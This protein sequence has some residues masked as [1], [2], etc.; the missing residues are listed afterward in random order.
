MSTKIT[1]RP[2][3]KPLKLGDIIEYQCSWYTTYEIIIAIRFPHVRTLT[4]LATEGIP[5]RELRGEKRHLY[6]D[7][8]S[9]SN[10]T[11]NKLLGILY[12]G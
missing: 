12:G 11:K 2:Q 4:I 1:H 10:I 5:F 7:D 8:T 3:N 6:K 9:I